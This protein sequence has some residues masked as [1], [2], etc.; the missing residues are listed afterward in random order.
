MRAKKVVGSVLVLLLTATATLTACSNSNDKN[1][2]ANNGGTNN[3]GKEGTE[4]SAAFTLGSQPLNFSFYGN[5]DWMTTAPWGEDIPSQWLRDEMKITVEPIQSGGAAQQKMSTMLAGDD[6]PDVIMLDRGADVEKLVTAGKLVAFDEYLDKYPNLKKWAGEE[7]L[8]MLRSSDGKLYQFPN[9]Y[10][11]TPNGNAGYL[12]NRKIYK[13]LGSPKLVTFDD[14]YAY[15]KS[16]KEKYPNV[17]PLETDVEGQ[18]VNILASGFAEDYVTTWIGERGVPSGDKFVSLF[19]D[20]TFVETMQYSSKLFR[21]KLITQD[22]LTQKKE[23]ITEK[24]KAGRVAVYVSY[25]VLEPSVAE[26]NNTMRAADPDSGYDVIW[27]LHKAGLDKNKIYPNTFNKLGW[28]VNVITTAAENPEGIFAYLDWLTGPEGTSTVFYGPKG[29]Y[30]S[31]L[32]ENEYPKL[33]DTWFSTPQADKDKE[34]LGAVMLTGNTTYLDTMKMSLEQKMKPEQR[35][36]TNTMQ[37]TI[38]WKTSKDLTPFVN[39]NP[40]GDSEEGIAKTAVDDIFK[41]YFAQALFAKSD[42]E[43]VAVLKKAEAEANAQGYEKLLAYKTK[44][45]Q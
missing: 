41:K 8:N 15:L 40:S 25:S 16:V 43:V 3:G 34:K 23:Q 18:G 44:M 22:T 19:S 31:E 27:P 36:W 30:W 37:S 4:Q 17:V 7:T 24:I 12:I 2:P 6:L 42:D 38:T 9:W 21:E 32:D 5:Y 39:L 26:A 11:T 29:K 28:N 13:E 10:T 45:W 33:N 20:P 35:Q 14:L 1:T